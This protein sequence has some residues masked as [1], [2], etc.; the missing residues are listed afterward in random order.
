MSMKI[1]QMVKA[2]LEQT[3]K[4]TMTIYRELLETVTET[5]TEAQAA[6]LI[7]LMEKLD[8]SPEQ[9]MSEIVALKEIRQCEPMEGRDEGAV[10]KIDAA[11]AA[12]HKS[13]EQM[14]I[15]IEA[16]KR[17]HLQVGFALEQ[18][19]NE[20][21][22]IRNAVKKLHKLREEHAELL[23]IESTEPKTAA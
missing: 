18:A 6:M 12:L 3:R 23:G 4:E 19:Q 9:V 15:E 20:M 1:V 2:G 22:S 16:A 5:P 14:R 10:K 13:S 7:K 17:R 11:V 21:Y 8:K